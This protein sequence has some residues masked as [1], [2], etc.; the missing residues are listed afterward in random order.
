MLEWS[1]AFNEFNKYSFKSFESFKTLRHYKSS[2]TVKFIYLMFPSLQVT[3]H[4]WKHGVSYISNDEC[5]FISV[6]CSCGKV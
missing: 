3:K 6:R 4:Q 2:K 1:K 5:H